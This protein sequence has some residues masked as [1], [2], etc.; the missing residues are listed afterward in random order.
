MQFKMR[1][2]F[3][4]VVG[5]LL[6]LAACRLPVRPEDSSGTQRPQNPPTN[7]APLPLAEEQ[8]WILVW[9]DEFNDTQLDEEN[10]I[11]DINDWGGGNQELQYYT[12]RSENV[13]LENGF[14]HIVG[15]KESYRTRDYTSARLNSAQSWTYG[16][17][18][19]KAK[20]PEGQGIWPAIWLRSSTDPYGS[21]PASGEIDIMEMLGH[22]PSVIYGTLHYGSPWPDNEQSQGSTVLSSTGF[23][24]F[25]L[26]WEV[27]E[28]RWYV[29]DIHYLTIDSW[30]SNGGEFPAPFDQPLDVVLNLAIGGSWPGDPD[31]STIFPQTFLIDYVRVYKKSQVSEK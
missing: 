21:W 23:H 28:I 13:Y 2:I 8:A 20:L 7:E 9:Q 11:A 1:N 19:I 26:E 18:E 31:D 3:I 16:R 27:D 12:D 30:Y 5:L 29:D 25:A 24:E 14:L 22:E 17:F 4:G 10:W 6:V 15:R